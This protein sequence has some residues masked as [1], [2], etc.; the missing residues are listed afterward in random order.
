MMHSAKDSGSRGI[1]RI[2]VPPVLVILAILPLGRIRA[3]QKAEPVLC[4]GDYQTEEQ[5]KEQLARFASTYTNLRQWQARAGKIRKAILQGAELDPLPRK[6]PLNPIVHSLRRHAGYT[7]ENVAFESLPSVFVTGSL[8]RP[9]TGEAPFPAVL[10]P[11]CHASRP[12]DYG[13]FRE[14]QQKRCATLARMGAIVFSYDMVGWGDWKNAGWS[15]RR[16]KVLKLQLW[17]SIRSVD[18]VLT[19]ADVDPKRIG[20]TGCSG[21]G[22]QSFMLTAVDD[23]IAVS[24][25][26]VMVSAYF[27]GG[28]DCESGI[29][30]HKT[31]AHE[32]SNVEFAALAAPRPQLLISCGGDWTEGHDY[33]YSKRVPAYRFLAKHLGLSLS[34]VSGPDGAIDESFVTIEKQ[35]DMYA[36]SDEHP[37]PAHAVRPEVSELPWD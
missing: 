29:T 11:H 4:Q 22:T 25:P 13:R 20:V 27:F 17:N 18:F 15:H 33:G 8:Y 16:P 30:I 24:V 34:K 21:G 19:L 35:E 36:F 14:D 28:C 2:V 7:V 3:G 5:A 12:E 1:L 26:A 9:T 32:T 31:A 10:C 23:R 6:R 37:R